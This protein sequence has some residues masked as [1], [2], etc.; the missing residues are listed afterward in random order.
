MAAWSVKMLISPK[1][2]R[3]KILHNYLD[4]NFDRL[5]ESMSLRRYSLVEALTKGWLAQLD[6]SPEIPNSQA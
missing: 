6:H 3:E 4:K 1:A 2:L 5:E